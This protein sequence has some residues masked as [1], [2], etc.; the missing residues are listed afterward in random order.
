MQGIAAFRQWYRF[1]EVIGI[2][3]PL[4]LEQERVRLVHLSRDGQH[5]AVRESGSEVDVESLVAY[6]LRHPGVPVS[7]AIVGKGIL[8]K[9]VPAPKDELS[10]GDIRELFPAFSFETYYCIKHSGADSVWVAIVKKTVLDEFVKGLIDRG[11]NL[12]EV[13][14]GPF[15]F[16]HIL[17]LMN[18]YNGSYVFDGHCITIDGE[19]AWLSY[20]TGKEY[21]AV[22]TLKIG[23][24]TVDQKDMAAYSAGFHTL[25][26]D[27]LDTKAV[28]QPVLETS[29][30]EAYQKIKFRNNG[31]LLLAVVF[32]CLLVSTLVFNG[33]Y[34]ANQ[35]LEGRL[36]LQS[37]SN[38]Q[39][40]DIGQRIGMM[41]GGLK[42]IGW[43]GGVSKAW[44]L[45]QLAQSVAPHTGI[46][47]TK[48]V[49][50]PLPDQRQKNGRALHADNRNT[51]TISGRAVSLAGLNAWVRDLSRLDWVTSVQI[52]KFGKPDLSVDE[53]NVFTLSLTFGYEIRS[54]ILQETE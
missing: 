6:T 3:A 22:Y 21:Q 34:A 42:E 4:D 52:A 7:A 51:I 54:T 19:G 15:H 36:S 12:V 43:N 14:V 39:V 53:S 30:D 35:E 17:M 25:M 9:E 11:I 28:A 27:N 44:L 20:A 23:N 40:D 41:E 46:A 24:K 1:K 50:N 13:V 48:I 49:I 10:E 47:W 38:R 18:L 37:S 32:V 33:Y 31:I 5:L 8:V 29:L 2:S 16:D 45:D 26:G